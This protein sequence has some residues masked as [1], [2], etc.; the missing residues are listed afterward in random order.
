MIRV[1]CVPLLLLFGIAVPDTG[2]AHSVHVFAYVED[3][4]IKG[5]G[6]LAGGSAVKNGVVTILLKNDGQILYTGRTDENGLFSVPVG[7]LGQP[8][9]AELT[10]RLDAG[11][12]HRSQW[13]LQAEEFKMAV[14]KDSEQIRAADSSSSRM[15]PFPPL[16]NII[17]GLICILGLG[18][19]IYL[20]RKKGGK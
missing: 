10:V 3:G 9:P 7:Q 18:F 8:E 14:P 11:P 19:L 17:T 16:K 13:H 12:G 5:E 20:S 1:L 6:S 4:Q 2:S 15:A